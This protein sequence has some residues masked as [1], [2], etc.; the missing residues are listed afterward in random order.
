MEVLKLNI[1]GYG[2]LVYI[3]ILDGIENKINLF[4]IKC[5]KE[6]DKLIFNIYN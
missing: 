1:I 4:L 6:E 5:I 3:K 2:L